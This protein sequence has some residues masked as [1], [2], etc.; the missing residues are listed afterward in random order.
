MSRVEPN[1]YSPYATADPAWRHIIPGLY[2]TTPMPGVLAPTA[3]GALAV[4]PD[5]VTDTRALETLPDGLC[6]VCLL[7]L[8]GDDTNQAAPPE[9]E[10]CIECGNETRNGLCAVCRMELHDEWRAHQAA[11]TSHQPGPRPAPAAGTQ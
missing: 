11:A 3:C 6:P 10:P 2:L 1:P 4:V 9:A 8:N 5:H 7:V